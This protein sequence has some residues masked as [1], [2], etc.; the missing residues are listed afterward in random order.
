MEQEIKNQPKQAR[1]YL[2]TYLSKKPDAKIQ[3]AYLALQVEHY[4]GLLRSAMVAKSM[5]L[6]S[7]NT[8]R[9]VDGNSKWGAWS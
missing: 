6:N 7:N 9:K 1:E 4:E 5:I 2:R 8:F 3:I